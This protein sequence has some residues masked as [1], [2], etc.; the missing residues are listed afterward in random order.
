VAK[1]QTHKTVVETRSFLSG[2]TV[3]RRRTY[4]TLLGKTGQTFTKN[5]L[6]QLSGCEL[7]RGLELKPFGL[8]GNYSW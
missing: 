2:A 7:S 1:F 3:S 4:E 5:D 6:L 8:G